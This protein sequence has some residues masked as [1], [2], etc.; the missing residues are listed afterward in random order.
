MFT[1]I[2]LIG[3]LI[4]LDIG[5]LGTPLQC[6]FKHDLWFYLLLL[7]SNLLI[8]FD[9]LLD[10]MRVQ[11]VDNVYLVGLMRNQEENRAKHLDFEMLVLYYLVFIFHFKP[12]V[13]VWYR[14]RW[15]IKYILIFKIVVDCGLPFFGFANQN[16]KNFIIPISVLMDNIQ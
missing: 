12:D 4:Q 16:I 5:Y 6:W 15:S 10:F 7:A 14:K 8:E 9:Q 2:R 1:K 13:A 3:T 11:A